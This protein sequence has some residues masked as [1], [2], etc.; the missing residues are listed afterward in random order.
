MPIVKKKFIFFLFIYTVLAFYTSAYA[1]IFES[2]EARYA[3]IAREMIQSGNFIE[4]YFNGIKHFHKPPLTYWFIASGMKIFGINNFGSRFF[5][6]I[7]SI[8]TLVFTV[9]LSKFFIREE[10]RYYAAYVLSSSILFLTVSRIAATDIYL[11][12]F[13]VISQYYYFNQVYYK[14]DTKNAILIGIFLGFGFITKGPIIFLFTLLPFFVMK[15]F[16]YHFRKVFSFKD[17]ILST[18]SFIAVSL[19]W[20][21]IVIIKNPDLLN[22]FLKVQTIERV[23]TNRF[24]REK[25]FYFFFGTVFVSTLPY[26]I[27]IITKIKQLFSNY[28]S[29]ITLI[30]YIITPFI[31]FSIAKSKLHSYL[32][33]LTPIMSILVLKLYTEYCKPIFNKIVLYFAALLPITFIIATFLLK[34][35]RFNLTII[36]LSIISIAFVVISRKK[37]ENHLFSYNLGLIVVIIFNI[38]YYSSSIFQDKLMGFENMVNA[39]NIID[40]DRKLEA[41]CY[42]R[43]LPSTS[44]YRNKITVM[45]HGTTR[46]TQFEKDDNYKKYYIQTEDEMKSFIKS[47]SSFFLFTKGALNEFKDKYRIDCE[48]KYIQ[49]DYSLSLCKSN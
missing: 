21:L 40:P 13:T 35:L 32:T 47:N 46:E 16:D 30:V 27:L 34:E 12:M 19:P 44:F 24:N 15:F 3:E 49:R 31:I 45:A 38:I 8:I 6:I 42:K 36:I 23:T 39:A 26:S 10:E 41:L 7:A 4:P 48:E 22:Y 2:T 14:K 25:P 9:K 20:Y 17:V 11:T 37:I 5:G 1:P 28:K 33:P 29:H 18:I 43:D